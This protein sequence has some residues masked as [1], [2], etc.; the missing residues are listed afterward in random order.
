[1]KLFNSDRLTASD[2]IQI[3][4]CQV[5][6][7]PTEAPRCLF[8]H[9][10][11]FEC[12]SFGGTTIFSSGEN[13]LQFKLLY[14]AAKIKIWEMLLYIEERCESCRFSAQLCG[15]Q[16]STTIRATAHQTRTKERLRLS[17]F[18]LIARK[19][20]Q[21]TQRKTDT[22]TSSWHTKMHF[23]ASSVKQHATIQHGNTIKDN[24][25][26]YL[27]HETCACQ[28]A[29]FS[30]SRIQLSKTRQQVASKQMRVL[31]LTAH[32]K[33][34]LLATSS[35]PISTGRTAQSAEDLSEEF[36]ICKNIIRIFEDIGARHSRR[37]AAQFPR[38]TKQN[39]TVFLHN[40]ITSIALR[41]AIYTE[42]S[43]KIN[44]PEVHTD[45]FSSQF[46]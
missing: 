33:T 13:I 45:T 12:R 6:K 26:Y 2:V 10:N 29:H 7:Q 17:N 40:F 5:V 9:R 27:S 24:S 20:Q 14:I 15:H 25:R 4:T 22:I 35:Y 23:I 19:H 34:T 39:P 8:C 1:M 32:F 38:A 18:A 16:L 11:Y 21:W 28:R 44:I 3:E 42:K 41:C 46:T 30:A 43:R 36:F 31:L 37:T